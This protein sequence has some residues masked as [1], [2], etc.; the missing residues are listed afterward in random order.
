MAQGR[1]ARVAR[2]HRVAGA[3]RERLQGSMRTSALGRGR[4]K[5]RSTAVSRNIDLSERAVFDS[6]RVRKGKKTPENEMGV[7]FHTASVDL[8]RSQIQWREPDCLRIARAWSIILHA[9][10]LSKEC[11]IRSQKSLQLDTPGFPSVEYSR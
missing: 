6:F 2:P 10:Q 4:V 3:T 1:V 8:S 9:C 7:C 5:T 11:K